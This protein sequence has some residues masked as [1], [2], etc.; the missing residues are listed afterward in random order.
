MISHQPLIG[1]S[2]RA[3]KLPPQSPAS[4]LLKS[5]KPLSDTT[6][7]PLRSLSTPSTRMLNGNFL[8][9]ASNSPRVLT[10]EK[11]IGKFINLP[12]FKKSNPINLS[13]S[14]GAI[15]DVEEQE[16]MEPS[17]YDTIASSTSPPKTRMK[18]VEMAS[19]ISVSISS[20]HFLKPISPWMPTFNNKSTY[21]KNGS[22]I[23]RHWRVELTFK[24]ISSTR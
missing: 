17:S 8:P 2:S 12:P 23:F 16:D 9:S 21:G 15:E 22:N 4:G 1:S 14:F 5:S 18:F 19:Q 6:T 10:T 13:S 7:I 3:S 20:W 24:T 11:T